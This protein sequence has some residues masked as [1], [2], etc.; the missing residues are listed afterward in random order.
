M[1]IIGLNGSPNQDGNT[2]LLLN[3]ALDA[4]E[5]LGAETEIIQV[6][7][8]LEE[9]EEP[10]CTS[11]SQPCAKVCYEGT[12]L[13]EDYDLLTKADGVIIGSPVYFGTVSAQLKGFWDMTRDL[14]KEFSLLNTVGGGVTVGAGRFG[15]QETTL[16]AIHD[17]MLVQGMIVVGDGDDESDAGHQG[18]AAQRLAAED[19]NGQLRAEIIGRRVAKVAN[20]TKSLR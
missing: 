9:L 11:C 19:E 17:M 5:E 20:A 7:D 6:A 13:E 8:S 3:K 10:Y 15:G 12:K 18:A 1:L 16:N 14:R 2:E 4:A